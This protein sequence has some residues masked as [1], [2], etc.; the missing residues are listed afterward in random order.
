M[1]GGRG[2]MLTQ[3][4]WQNLLETCTLTKPVGNVYFDKTCWK[5][6]LWQ[7]LLEMCTLTKPVGDVYFDKTCWKSVHWQNLLET[8]TLTKPVGNVYFDKTCWKRV[9][10]Q[11]LLETCILTKPV[12]NVY[13]D[14]TCWKRVHWQNL[15]ETCT[16]TKPVG[17]VYI[18][19]TCWK[20]VFWQ[21]LL[22][23]CTL[24]KPVGNVYFESREGA[25]RLALR[26]CWKYVESMG[27]RVNVSS[28]RSCLTADFVM[29]GV[30]WYYSAARGYW[31]VEE[32][33]EQADG[34]TGYGEVA[35]GGCLFAWN[36]NVTSLPV[37]TEAER[38]TRPNTTLS[39]H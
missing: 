13:I 1:A 10:W 29:S 30:E 20:R 24:T 26:M 21:K 9:H 16:L 36:F 34:P 8:C 2:E 19:K 11:N 3:F 17:N 31:P 32:L 5:R 18:D 27:S 4:R 12:G 33:G 25:V 38:S 6:V 7:N 14:K 35:R 28:R 39:L 37:L 22:E 23:T 15:L